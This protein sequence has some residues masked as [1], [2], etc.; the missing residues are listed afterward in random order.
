MK[1]HLPKMLAA[2]VVAAMAAT[3]A[4]AT[5]LDNATVS[6]SSFTQENLDALT[7]DGW[8]LTGITGNESGVFTSTGS[9]AK[10]AIGDSG[11]TLTTNH[12]SGGDRYTWSAIVTVQ[13]DSLKSA[14]SIL[15]QGG[16]GD[17][18]PANNGLG[19]GASES[20]VT[21]TW[22]NNAS[23]F[24]MPAN[25]DALDNGDGT[26]TLGVVYEGGNGVTVYA[27]GNSQNNSGLKWTTNSSAI[28]L[29]NTSGIQ[30]ANLY[31]FNDVVSAADMKSMISSFGS[32]A[33]LTW[34]GTEGN[35][36]WDADSTNWKKGEDS[37]AFINASNTT[38]SADAAVAKT[39]SVSGNHV[40]HTMILQD[41]YTFD[42]QDGASITASS[43]SLAAGKDI[44]LTGRG[45]LATAA[46]T[47]A[48]NGTNTINL[49]EGTS[50]GIDAVVDV[51]SS[52]K[53]VALGAGDLRV[54]T[55][56][57]TGG[58]IE[59][60]A[61]TEITGGGNGQGSNNNSL[62]LA[63]TNGGG[64]IRIKAGTTIV[65]GAT[66]L[67]NTTGALRVGLDGADAKLVTNRLETGDRNGGASLLEIGSQGTVVVTSTNDASGNTDSYKNTGLI[68]SEWNHTTTANVAGK[69]L[70]KDVHLY[71]GDTKFNLN[72]QNGGV[73]AVKG[74]AQS[75]RTKDNT[76]NEISLAAGGKLVLGSAGIAANNQGAWAINL[77]GGEVGMSA[78]AVTIAKNATLAGSVTFN[79][80]QYTFNGT[81]ADQTLEAGTA[82]GTMTVS[83]VL[84]GEGS[85]VK[86]GNGTL[87]L[88]GANT[89]SGGTT[90]NGGTL[91]VTNASGLGSGA[92]TVA[93]GAT[94]DIGA[95]IT[96]S[97]AIA[98]S[99]TVVF[100]SDINATGF[101]VTGG[102]SGFT[103][104]SGKL[105]K[106]GNGFATTSAASITI[107]SGS[108]TANDHTVT[109]GEVV[110]TI[111]A[112]GTAVSGDSSVDYLFYY[113]KNG[114]VSASAIAGAA[115]A[116]SSVCTGVMATGGTLT[117]DT[118]M[119][120]LSAS[121]NAVV[122]FTGEGSCDVLEV[123][124]AATV[125]GNYDV[126]SVVIDSQAT[127]TMAGGITS[128]GVSFTNTDNT[129]VQVKNT[130]TDTEADG[131]TYSTGEAAAQ[132]TAD[133]LT[134]TGADN[135]TISNQLAVA[136]ISNEGAGKLIVDGAVEGL[137]ALAAT[138]G[139]ITLQKVEDV[140]AVTSLSIGENK[141]VAVYAP[142][143]ETANAPVESTLNV[144][145]TLT[146]ATGSTLLSNLV[147]GNGATLA[148]DDKLTLGS[149][150]TL[151]TGM[152]LGG[153]L[154]TQV[155][156]LEAGSQ[157]DLITSA[158]NTTLTYAGN[159]YDGQD[160]NTYFSNLA[161]GQ[162]TIVADG[163][164]VAIQKT[165]S[166]PVVPEP[167]TGTLS[168]LALAGLM[169]RRRR[170]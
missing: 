113:Q 34:A 89:Y 12:A 153:A 25:L 93:S 16:G 99:G 158:A 170:K 124:G 32:Y 94:L 151:G 50:M 157:V 86:T 3:G 56:R 37:V 118:Y 8:T 104:V 18:N 106:D 105:T 10:I 136:A 11:K 14:A 66:Y 4:Y 22:Q 42:I 156:G 82:A 132:V 137:E 78:E 131:I 79:T 162:Y 147:L 115:E 53:L 43:I 17:A 125:G 27:G 40:A 119:S 133:K 2:A 72:I 116:A 155:Q 95:G 38:F 77:N 23:Y 144:T 59:L 48:G 9:Q 62:G 168:L 80:A 5:S 57:S 112:D 114:E 159:G 130:N 126:T 120:M 142:G 74:I 91:S 19:L 6:I 121:D 107:A 134:N 67:G 98:N 46:F 135:V 52:R 101:E 54:T 55:L 7:A 39:V 141:T 24:S 41:S 92:V 85:L 152:T 100:N 123:T 102:E 149:Q 49:A 122:T 84:S 33:D 30:Y 68:F 139:D 117:V 29:S 138:S 88:S 128:G 1:L 160:A 163:T 65:S 150:L 61:D 60:S 69:L 70:A 20:A 35:N 73:V 166:S 111:Q 145:E 167:T 146:S 164:H 127:A 76:A 58:D 36:A 47:V 90:V 51:G 109:Q 13:K 140:L 165:G 148:L 63:L 28:S 31:W 161:A 108:V 96:L 81:G 110:Y 75:I 83:G 143:A 129:G 26:V 97:S 169:A 71:S 64:Q 154:N 87:V 103:D 21:G 44:T 15:L 45:T